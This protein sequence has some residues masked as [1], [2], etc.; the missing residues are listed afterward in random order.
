[1]LSSRGGCDYSNP[2]RP[3]YLSNSLLV[4]VLVQFVALPFASL[5]RRFTSV[6]TEN[7]WMGM[8]N[9]SL[10]ALMQG[11]VA[12]LNVISPRSIARMVHGRQQLVCSTYNAKASLGTDR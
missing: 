10:R 4:C 12:T 3:G 5:I 11:F 2:K 9:C 6:L 1:M 8:V 7:T